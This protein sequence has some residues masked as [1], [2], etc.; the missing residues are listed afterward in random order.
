MDSVG[1]K[2]NDRRGSVGR[3]EGGPVLVVGGR[4][5]SVVDSKGDDVAWL[6]RVWRAAGADP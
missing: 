5:W 3:E 4:G 6:K 2:T 1:P